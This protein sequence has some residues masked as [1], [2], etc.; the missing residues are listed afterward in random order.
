MNAT[1]IEPHTVPTGPRKGVFRILGD[2]FNRYV[3]EGGMT[4]GAALT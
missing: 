3:M 2:A 4:Y 1:E